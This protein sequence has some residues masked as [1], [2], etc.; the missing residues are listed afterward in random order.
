LRAT[1][2]S[3]RFGTVQAVAGVDLT[4]RPGRIV[5]LIGPNGAGKTT[6]IDA[7]SGYVRS[8]TGQVELGGQCLDGW[9]A[10]RRSAAGLGRCFQSL[11]LFDDLTV[12]E[13]LLVAAEH[14]PWHAWVTDTCR[15]RSDGLPPAI[16]S[17]VDQLDLNEVL[18]EFPTSLSYGDRKLVAV[19]R[20]LASAPSVLLLDEPAA[21]LTSDDAASL[22][23]TL[24]TIA[25]ELGIGI[26][27]VEHDIDLVAAISDELVVM[28]FGKVLASG[29]PTSV[30]SDERVI[31]AYLGASPNAALTSGSQP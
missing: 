12:R 4:V 17:V 28:E 18:D 8:H 6:M 13:N 15:R 23:R 21:G 16:H 1:G 2:L 3:V 29:T 25:D 11:E 24:R 20:S 5:G 22:A 7:I 27:L 31:E 9:S 19:A 26:L 30:L 14:V 10:H